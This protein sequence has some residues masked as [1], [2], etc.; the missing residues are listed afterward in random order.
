MIYHA[1][2]TLADQEAFAKPPPASTDAPSFDYSNIYVPKPWGG[3][4]LV[5][6]NESVAVWFLSINAGQSTSMHAHAHKR[7]ALVVMTGFA[8]VKTLTN[9]YILAPNDVVLIEPGVFHSTSAISNKIRI[10]E[11]ETPP[12]KEDL[13]R[14]SD[15]YG[16]VNQGYEKPETYQR[17]PVMDVDQSQVKDAIEI[18]LMCLNS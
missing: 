18:A 6:Q 16:R 10:I 12:M 3:E 9:E 7:T 1:H 2:L 4:Y 14:L 11:A 13:I 15:N 8:R 17:N 5:A